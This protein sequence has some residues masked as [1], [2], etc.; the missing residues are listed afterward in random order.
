MAEQENELAFEHYKSAADLGYVP[1]QI[2][3]AN[4]FKQGIGCTKSDKLSLHY[5]SLAAAQNNKKAFT[6]I[7]RFYV[8]NSKDFA[9][10]KSYLKP[11]AA[12]EHRNAQLLLSEDFS[13]QI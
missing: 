10:V 11:L 1:S 2:N 4:Y 13:E 3:V 7:I 5:Y 9:K 12:L 6:K 8:E